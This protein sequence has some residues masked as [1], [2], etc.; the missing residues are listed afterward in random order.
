MGVSRERLFDSGWRCRASPRSGLCRA[1]EIDPLTEPAIEVAAGQRGEEAAD[2][3]RVHAID[4][5]AIVQDVYFGQY[6]FAR[7]ILPPGTLGFNPRIAGSPYDPDKAKRLLGYEPQTD[8]G[9][10]LVKT[11]A[12]FQQNWG[13]LM[14]GLGAIII[15][16]S[17][18]KR[19]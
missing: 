10:G 6:I 15:V 7:G 14:L 8:L 19:R 16:P 1:I 13:W 12:W 9:T 4:R 11:I 18:L 17:A 2:G 5:E 3:S